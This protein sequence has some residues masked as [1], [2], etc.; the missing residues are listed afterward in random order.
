MLRRLIRYCD[1]VF[2]L[3]QRL[4]RIRDRRVFPRITTLEI[5]QSL[6]VMLWSR[7]GSFNA[8]AATARSRFCSTWLEAAPSADTCGYVGARL[9]TEDLRVAIHGVYDQLKRNKSLP[10]NQGRDVAVLDGHESHVSY[11]RH[12]RACLRRTVRT[13][14]GDRT[15]YYHRHVALMLLPGALP[16]GQSLRLLL[17]LEPVRAG[18]D[19][20]AAAMRLLDRVI[21]RYP[22]AFDLVLADALYA[23][24]PFVRFLAERHKHALVVFKQ[25]AT[26]LSREAGAELSAQPGV[27][28]HYRGRACRWRDSGELDWSGVPVRV[29]VIRS[30]ETWT[31]HAQS[32]GQPRL[33]RAHWMWLTTLAAAQLPLDRFVNLAHQRWDIENYGFNELVN[34]WHA[35]HVYKHEANAIEALL[36][37]TCLAFNLYYAFVLRCLKP[38]LR[39]DKPAAY[40][41][42]LILAELHCAV[43]PLPP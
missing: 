2:D 4:G 33:H 40:W 26:E 37:L 36:L 13:E 20:R 14:Q 42:R 8:L 9:E 10:L 17:D 31:T 22:R 15:Q 5:T 23:V 34:G 11:L 32:T 21:G 24:A 27:E 18:E 39:R 25:E 16:G 38:Q 43:T 30:E 6:L 35:D 3:R 1:K 12:C 29:R 41:A 28:G 19:E 7:L